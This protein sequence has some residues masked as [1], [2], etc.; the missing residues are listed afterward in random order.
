VRLNDPALPTPFVVLDALIYPKI[1]AFGD[2]CDKLSHTDEPEGSS[3][4]SP[5][6]LRA[7]VRPQWPLETGAAAGRCVKQ[8][9]RRSQR[10]SL[11]TEPCANAAATVMTNRT[12]A[13][14]IV[15]PSCRAPTSHPATAPI[16]IWIKPSIAEA[17]PAMVG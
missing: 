14:G 10:P 6:A 11:G 12:L 1:P 16:A 3:M 17:L 9:A 4:P 8:S 5:G 13:M 2:R 15:V 7:Q